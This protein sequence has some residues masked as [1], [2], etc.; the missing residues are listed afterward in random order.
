MNE[1]IVEKLDHASIR[2][3]PIFLPMF[4]AVKKNLVGIGCDFDF[5]LVNEELTSYS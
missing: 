1:K 4:Q 3:L 2:W 5:L